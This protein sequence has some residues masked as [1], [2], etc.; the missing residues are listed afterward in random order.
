MRIRLVCLEDGII[1]CGFRKMAAWVKGLHPETEAYYV[2]TNSWAS[3]SGLLR[4]RRGD[5]GDFRRTRSTRSRRS[6]PTPI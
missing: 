2:S 4:G 5:R 6:W 3:M 1:S